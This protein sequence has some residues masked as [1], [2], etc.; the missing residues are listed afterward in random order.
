MVASV[1]NEDAANGN[2]PKAFQLADGVLD[3]SLQVL[4]NII[5]QHVIFYFVKLWFLIYRSFI[6]STLVLHFFLVFWWF[7]DLLSSCYIAHLW[8][9][10][11]FLQDWA[12]SPFFVI[13][14]DWG[15]SPFFMPA[16]IE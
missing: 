7:I 3:T 8:S 4:A 11:Y 16:D 13:L 15:L 14:Q 10:H 1:F 2:L 5:S 9:E 12:L 6:A